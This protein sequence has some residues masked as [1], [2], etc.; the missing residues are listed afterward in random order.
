MKAIIKPSQKLSYSKSSGIIIVMIA[1]IVLKYCLT[2][3][4]GYISFSVMKRILD[5]EDK[6]SIGII[7]VIAIFAALLTLGDKLN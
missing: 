1:L 4:S 3:I 2:F 7:V 5:L 6:T